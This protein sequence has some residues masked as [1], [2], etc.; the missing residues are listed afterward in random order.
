MAAR[1]IA[2]AAVAVA[3]AGALGVT[4]MMASAEPP[5]GHYGY[6]YGGGGG[7]PCEPNGLGLLGIVEALLELLGLDSGDDCDGDRPGLLDLPPLDPQPGDGTAPNGGASN[8]AR[9]G[10]D[11][12]AATNGAHA[13]TDSAVSTGTPTGSGGSTTAGLVDGL[14]GGGDARNDGSPGGRGDV[15][16]GLAD[17][18]RP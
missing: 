5:R 1:G 11:A 18:G 6:G 9:G 14:L 3:V 17:L 2:R 4:T 13:T 15:R 12:S 10:V 7:R 8:D 16:A